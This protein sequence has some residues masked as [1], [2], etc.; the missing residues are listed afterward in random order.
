MGRSGVALDRALGDLQGRPISLRI[1]LA[2]AALDAIHA[3]S[4]VQA[5]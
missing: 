2:D 3:G 5:Q 4:G 1:Y